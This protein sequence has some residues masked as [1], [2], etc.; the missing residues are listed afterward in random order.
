M[1]GKLANFKK[2]IVFCLFLLIRKKI[3]CVRDKHVKYT[4]QNIK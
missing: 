2:E 3:Q 4:Y 1:L